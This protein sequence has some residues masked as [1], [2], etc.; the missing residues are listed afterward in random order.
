MTVQELR[1]ALEGLDGDV[2]VV[3]SKD[4]E[5]NG[6]SP[7]SDVEA[8]ARYA[9]DSTWSGEVIHRDDWPDYPAA[10]PVVCLWPTN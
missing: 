1:D 4:G 9:P 2:L 3:M 7:L 10:Q 6:Y 8:D 5:G